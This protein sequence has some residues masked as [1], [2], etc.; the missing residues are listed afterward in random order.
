AK[1]RNIMCSLFSHACRW[2]FTDRNPVIHVRP[3]TQRAKQPVVLSDGEIIR[4]LPEIP[5]P[6]RTAV[7]LAL[8][9]GLRV[10]ELLALQWQDVDFSNNTI[11]PARGIVDNHIGGLKTVASGNPVPA[12]ENVIA[13]LTEWR[14]RTLY[15]A[16]T[17]WIFPSPR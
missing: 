14:K 16:P 4:L 1:I 5:Q 13:V 8:A 3:A 7:F 17:D 2:E 9:T 10:S 11:T 15:P 12:D 6:A